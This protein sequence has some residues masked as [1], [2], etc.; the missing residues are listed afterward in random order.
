MPSCAFPIQYMPVIIMNSNTFYCIQYSK[1]WMG[2]NNGFRLTA[3]TSVSIIYNFNVKIS[4]H[5][6]S[7]SFIVYT[8]FIVYPSNWQTIIK[9]ELT[10]KP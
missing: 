7:L 5:E 8:T 10:M 2:Y 9:I 3:Y 6:T 4:F 1:G